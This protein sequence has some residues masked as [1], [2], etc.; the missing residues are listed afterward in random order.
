MNEQQPTNEAERA[1]VRI[2][3]V[4]IE[5][6]S[7]NAEK[8]SIL[9]IG[10]AWL[11]GDEKVDHFH[12]RC[13]VWDGA[14]WDPE[15]EAKHGITL[16]EA[17]DPSLPTEAQAVNEFVAWIGKLPV[18]LAGLNPSHDRAFTHAARRRAGQSTKVFPH[19]VVDLHS[20]AVEYALAKGVAVPDKGFYTDEIYELLGMP[21]EPKPHRATNGV[22]WELEALRMLMGIPGITE[23]V[24]YELGA[25]VA[26]ER[27]D[28]V[29]LIAEERRRQVNFFG[30][31]MAN[32]DRY[33]AEQ[34]AKAASAYALPIWHPNRGAGVPITWPWSPDCWKPSQAGWSAE[35]T[36]AHIDGRVRELAKA[37]A[38]LAAEMDRLL[39]R[40]AELTE[41]RS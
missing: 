4:D 32:D 40:K 33:L 11:L 41:L 36:A 35:P 6:S 20:M 34:L 17:S 3:V 26:G 30:F 16:A 27:C 9:E 24:P 5:T 22:M 28:G 13:R 2:L 7:L 15:S 25:T 14:E 23:P 12:R 21:A 38:L 29:A 39:R 19:R 31:D 1:G 10:A 18:L 8:G 37:G